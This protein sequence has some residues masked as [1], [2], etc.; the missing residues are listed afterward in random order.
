MIWENKEEKYKRLR[1]LWIELKKNDALGGLNEQE[2]R[3]E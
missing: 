2:N 3:D 1:K